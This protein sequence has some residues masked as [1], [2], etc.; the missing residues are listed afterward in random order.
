M[1]VGPTLSWGLLS[2]ARINDKVLAGARASDAVDVV[3]VASREAK[4]ARAYADER[5]IPV[6]HGSYEDLLADE[7][8]EAVYIGLPNALHVPW[9]LRALE[10]GKHV[11]VEK[12]FDR[13]VEPVERAFDLAEERGLVLSEGFMWRHNPQTH[14][15][16]ELVRGGAVGEVRVVKAAFSFPLPEAPNVRWDAELDGGALMDVGCYCVSAARLLC[17]EPTEVRGLSVG[18]G[19]D[20]RFAG[21]LG[22]GEDGPLATFDCGFDLPARGLLEVVGAGGTIVVRDP[23]HVNEPGIEVAGGHVAVERAD[24]Y[25]LELED[26]SEAAR[27]G[28]PPLLG[29]EDAVGQA[30]VLEALLG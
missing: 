10:A 15:L 20:R 30:R 5:G 19:V 23:W 28:R 6:A 13:R 2:T 22:F 21:L 3:A 16:V 29:R 11:L 7:R 9:T 18:D 27:T 14:R 8:V 25:R 17:G 24:S 1:S 4:R 12:P 26:V